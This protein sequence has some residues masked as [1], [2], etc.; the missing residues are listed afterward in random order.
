MVAGED[1]VAMQEDVEGKDH[2][3]PPEVGDSTVPPSIHLNLSPATLTAHKSV[4]QVLQASNEWF[5][6]FKNRQTG[7]FALIV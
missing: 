3:V 2:L 1:R 6:F 4:L 7:H 5:Y